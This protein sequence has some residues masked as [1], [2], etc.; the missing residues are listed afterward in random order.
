MSESGKQLHRS[1]AM[2]E[3]S[4]VVRMDFW[5]MCF[6]VTVGMHNGEK[7]AKLSDTFYIVIDYIVDGRTVV[8][9]KILND[10][11][12]NELEIKLR[13]GKSIWVFCNYKWSIEYCTHFLITF[14]SR[15]VCRSK[16]FGFGV[17]REK[18]KIMKLFC[19]IC[20]FFWSSFEWVHIKNSCNLNWA[21]AIGHF[22][23]ILHSRWPS[24]MITFAKR[25]AKLHLTNL[26]E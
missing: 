23:N 22:V 8:K 15:C 12:Q 25:M 21:R 6:F 19:W 9:W 18:K 11:K 2:N 10:G 5:R 7:R 3:R 20:C 17:K 16:R 1:N 14:F 4:N 26:F 13:N 24:T